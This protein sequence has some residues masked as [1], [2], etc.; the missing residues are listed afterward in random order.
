LSSNNNPKVEGFIEEIAF[1]FTNAEK[2]TEFAELK[3]ARPEGIVTVRAFDNSGAVAELR[4]DAR[5]GGYIVCAVTERE[6]KGND[7][8]TIIFRNLASIISVVGPDAA[9]SGS[10]PAPATAPS[11]NGGG[12]TPQGD[13]NDYI[14]LQHATA[15]SAGAYGD[16]IALPAETRGTFSDYLKNVA[17]GGAWL[18]EHHYKVLGYNPQPKEE[19]P[20]AP[21][22]PPFQ[23]EEPPGDVEI[24]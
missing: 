10:T 3:I 11:S 13:R 18:W 5:K 4:R 15:V 8:G 23:F 16:W 2:P 9:S 24:L 22:E 12:Y 14:M 1:K 7:G 6:G 17:L 20:P 21:E 19:A